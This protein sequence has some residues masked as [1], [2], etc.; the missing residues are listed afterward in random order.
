MWTVWDTTLDKIEKDHADEQP[1]LLL[2]LLAHFK[3]TIVQDEMFRPA[4][5]GISRLDD[6][7]AEEMPPE[8]R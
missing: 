2:T 7:L 8:S 5:L 6:E 4:A 1:G 3:G